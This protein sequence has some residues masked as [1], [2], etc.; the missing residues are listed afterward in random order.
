MVF[1]SVAPGVA[2]YDG[3][4]SR[5]FYRELRD[6]LRARPA[7]A[8]AALASYIPLNSLYGSGRPLRVEIPGREVPPGRDAPR[9]FYDSV[10]ERYWGDGHTNPPRHRH[11][12]QWPDRRRAG[13]PDIREVL[14]GRGSVGRRI[15]L[16]DRARSNRRA[17]LLAWC[18]TEV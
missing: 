4:R 14:A 3:A 13:Q 1:G 16:P 9:I 5:Q 8:D 11:R 7:V 12:G 18:R 15:I 6:R 17:R 10:D 2:G